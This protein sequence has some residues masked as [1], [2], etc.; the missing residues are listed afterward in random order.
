[1]QTEDKLLSLYFSSSH[2]SHRAPQQQK[3]TNKT[4]QSREIIHLHCPADTRCYQCRIPAIRVMCICCIKPL[5]CCS[6]WAGREERA[7]CR[8]VRKWALHHLQPD[9]YKAVLVL[10]H[11]L[12]T[13]V[14]HKGWRAH[15]YNHWLS[16]SLHNTNCKKWLT[17]EMPLPLSMILNERRTV[18]ISATSA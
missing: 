11:Y 10:Q 14:R 12:R 3:G 6:T 8:C 16:N 7:L 17:F 1:M 15:V 18:N 13:I 4:K 9:F 2:R 5:S